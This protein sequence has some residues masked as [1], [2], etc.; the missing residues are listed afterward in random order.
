[1]KLTRNTIHDALC[2]VCALGG[3]EAQL[4][5]THDSLTILC[6]NGHRFNTIELSMLAARV[7]KRDKTA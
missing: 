5:M 7:G 4:R 1:M 3:I 6:M 2:P